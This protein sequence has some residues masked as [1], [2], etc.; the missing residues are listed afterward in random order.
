VNELVKKKMKCRIKEKDI[1]DEQYEK[2]DKSRVMI[3]NAIK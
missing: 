1:L 2:Y 3:F